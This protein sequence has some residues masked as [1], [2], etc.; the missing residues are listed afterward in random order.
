MD[1]P[2]LDFDTPDPSPE[3]AAPRTR[4]RPARQP[5]PVAVPEP[6]PMDP[7][8]WFEEQDHLRTGA[9]T[10]EAPY[11]FR[12]LDE[13]WMVV[14]SDPRR[15][16]HAVAR[17][18]CDPGDDTAAGQARRQAEVAEFMGRTGTTGREKAVALAE[19]W[20]KIHRQTHSPARAPK[21]RPRRWPYEPKEHAAGAPISFEAD[22]EHLTGQV[23]GTS[24]RARH[25]YALTDDQRLFHVSLDTL[26][27]QRIA[28]GTDLNAPAAAPEEPAPAAE[29]AAS[30]P[31]PPEPLAGEVRP[32]SNFAAVQRVHEL[33]RAG[34]FDRARA[35][36]RREADD[37]IFGPDLGALQ[38]LHRR[39]EAATSLSDL[40]DREAAEVY[41]LARGAEPLTEEQRRERRRQAHDEHVRWL[42]E[43]L[44]PDSAHHTRARRL[45]AELRAEEHTALNDR[46]RALAHADDAERAPIREELLE[47]LYALSRTATA[48]EVVALVDRANLNDPDGAHARES[49]R[50]RLS[51]PP[52]DDPAFADVLVLDHD[53]RTWHLPATTPDRVREALHEHGFAAT[54]SATDPW[55]TLTEDLDTG[56]LRERLGRL[57]TTLGQLP[58]APPR[59]D[60]RLWRSRLNA[61]LQEPEDAR[62]AR[63]GQAQERARERIADLAARGDLAEAFTVVHEHI[64]DLR[65][66]GFLPGVIERNPDFEDLYLGVYAEAE[67]RREL[68]D[69]ELAMLPDDPETLEGMAEQYRR[70]CPHLDERT[71]LETV[72]LAA[73]DIIRIAPRSREEP[74]MSTPDRQTEPPHS[75]TQTELAELRPYLRKAMSGPSEARNAH[76]Q[77]IS[78][79]GVSNRTRKE[80]LQTRQWMRTGPDGQLY[81]TEEGERVREALWRQELDADPA[82]NPASPAPTEPGEPTMAEGEPT[83]FPDLDTAPAAERPPEQDPEPQQTAAPDRPAPADHALR[84]LEGWQDLDEDTRV[85]RRTRFLEEAYRDF[86]TRPGPE[87]VAL[88]DRANDIDPD[89]A[90]ARESLRSNLAAPAASDPAF[91][92][93]MVFD[94]NTRTWHVTPATPDSAREVLQRHGFA[95][96][97]SHTDPWL[98][99][100]REVDDPTLDRILSR[101]YTD[102]GRVPDAPPRLTRSLWWQQAVRDAPDSA[103]ERQERL[104]AAQDAVRERIAALVD[105]GDLRGAVDAVHDHYADLRR[106]GFLPGPSLPPGVTDHEPEFPDLYG[107]VLQQAQARKDAL[108][109]EMAAAPPQSPTERRSRA[110]EYRRQSPHLSEQAIRDIVGLQTSEDAEPA[111]AADGDGSAPPPEA[112]PEASAAQTPPDTAPPAG[113]ETP[114]P[115]PDPQEDFDSLDIG[116]GQDDIPPEWLA[117]ADEQVLEEDLVPLEDAP[118]DGPEPTAA[119]PE[120]PA[121]AQDAEPARADQDGAADRDSLSNPPTREPAVT[122]QPEAALRPEPFEGDLLAPDP[123]GD[124]DEGART[125]TS[126]GHGPDQRRTAAIDLAEPAPDGDDQDR[127]HLEVVLGEGQAPAQG[128]EPEGPARAG[129]VEQLP[130]QA[131]APDPHTIDGRAIRA[132]HKQWQSTWETQGRAAAITATEADVYATMRDQL[133]AALRQETNVRLVM[134]SNDPARVKEF[135]AMAEQAGFE[136]TLSAR[137]PPAPVRRMQGLAQLAHHFQEQTLQRA[138]LPQ[139]LRADHD[140]LTQI[141]TDAY[142]NRSVH[143]INLYNHTDHVP[144]SS[145]RRVGDLN[146]DGTWGETTWSKH[147]HIKEE[148]HKLEEA[149]ISKAER[150]WINDETTRIHQD[151]PPIEHTHGPY[152]DA[153]KAITDTIDHLR[154][155]QGLA[156]LNE[157]STVHVHTADGA[158]PAE[159]PEPAD[160][161]DP[162]PRPE[163]QDGHSAESERA[164][165]ETA[166]RRRRAG[167]GAARVDGDMPATSSAEHAPAHT[168]AAAP[169]R[170]RGVTAGR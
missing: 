86:S 156:Q 99:L 15:G 101:V 169:S 136:I 92:D 42:L 142:E 57:Y 134:P 23:W 50:A 157:T 115:A 153:H 165:A 85:Q 39:L 77:R 44:P 125:A 146:P 65:R 147:S 8:M 103:P 17:F 121:P 161:H 32:G 149:R 31:P 127:K 67:R 55:V 5:P 104:Q 38:G 155:K 120:P 151:L 52:A 116:A 81:L 75:L 158:A 43:V 131:P 18:P 128:E 126:F 54:H 58:E 83:L 66:N 2:V 87:T 97:Y 19:Q 24:P 143:R 102:L 14:A 93:V 25:R 119:A 88:I 1:Q 130:E 16:R 80:L 139:E 133:Q 69:I 79:E 150:R 76:G 11:V 91:A 111:R 35:Y 7:T 60:A 13:Y 106:G 117:L 94:R 48:P 46:I 113:E 122:E 70:Q 51:L 71:V 22:G 37:P 82:P 68:L 137:I 159:H 12:S 63:M 73:P 107:D 72:G 49:L 78:L 84:L 40:V 141:L 140:N 56:A 164:P 110:E 160:A 162:G 28:P 114:A 170:V 96:S 9:G 3:R 138:A 30:D 166:P 6:P 100:T 53:T 4:R 112:A 167:L 148:I 109:R 10:F 98:T 62:R 118:G 95:G 61:T 132:R 74:A 41:R 27:G 59:T 123:G 168:P 64:A 154:S 33:L 145:H 90:H 108:D 47:D 29:A 45:D 163:E 129:A 124:A 105:A 20:K 89:G 26:T 152:R 21:P 135:I 34:D 144:A 36:A